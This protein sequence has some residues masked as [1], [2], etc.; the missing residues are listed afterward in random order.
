MCFFKNKN[1]N[2]QNNFT[3]YSTYMCV[4]E[5]E[6]EKSTWTLREEYRFRVS[7]NRLLLRILRSKRK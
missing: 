6:R 2:A 3:C 7:E 4:R 5:R 1:L